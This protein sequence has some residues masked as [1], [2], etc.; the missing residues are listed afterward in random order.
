M[1]LIAKVSQIKAQ[2]TKKQGKQMSLYEEINYQELE[3][4]EKKHNWIV[5][6]IY[7]ASTYVKNMPF[8]ER[9]KN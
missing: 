9:I 5:E 3:L 1:V 8:Y 4:L 6:P 2:K 7:K